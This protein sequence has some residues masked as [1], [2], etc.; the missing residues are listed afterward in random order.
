MVSGSESTAGLEPVD[1]ACTRY[2]RSGSV[3]IAVNE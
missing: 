3:V 1:G 2:V